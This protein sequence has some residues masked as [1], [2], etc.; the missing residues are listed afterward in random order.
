MPPQTPPR[1]VVVTRPSQRRLEAALKDNSYIQD[2]RDHTSRGYDGLERVLLV[3]LTVAAIE[4]GTE[5]DLWAELH[6][7]FL[8]DEDRDRILTDALSE[9]ID[10]ELCR[11]IQKLLAWLGSDK[12]PRRMSIRSVYDFDPDVRARLTSMGFWYLQD[13]FEEDGMVGGLPR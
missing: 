1:S 7:A 9:L 12:Q 6:R 5:E 8:H 10:L 3:S 13:I 4:H 11:I 2:S